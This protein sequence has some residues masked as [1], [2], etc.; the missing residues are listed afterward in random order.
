MRL[1]RAATGHHTYSREDASASRRSTPRSNWGIVRG[2]RL[3]LAFTII[4]ILELYLLMRVGAE[5]GILATIGLIITTALLGATLTRLQG[6]R[7]LRR[8]QGSLAE[9]VMPAEEMIDGVLIFAAGL[10]LITPGFLT[11]TLGF[12]LLVPSSRR[13]IKRWLRR[14]FDAMVDRGNVRVVVTRFDGF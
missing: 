9:G 5:I 10:V 12:I 1:R 4:P 8:I 6:F 2:V 11:D 7:T 13:V 3:F 14:R